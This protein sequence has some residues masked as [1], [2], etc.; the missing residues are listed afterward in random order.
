MEAQSEASIVI[1]IVNL[2]RVIPAL[3]TV[4]FWGPISDRMGR[5]TVI[6]A[7]YIGVIVYAGIN[8]L[9]IRFGE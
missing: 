2:C 3:L 5:K 1:M 6:I 8:F 7:C 4:L 9:A